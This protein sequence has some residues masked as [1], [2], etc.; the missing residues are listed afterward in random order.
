MNNVLFTP[1][2][3]GRI[4]LG[5]RVVMAPLTRLRADRDGDMPNALMREHYRQRASDGGLII[6]EATTISPTA[7]GYLGAPGLYTDAQVAGWRAIVDAVHQRGGRILAQLWHVGR[8]SHASLAGGAA[9]VTASAVPYEGL[10]FTTAGWTPVSPAR[11]LETGEIA[12]IVADYAAAAQRARDAGFDGIEIHAA[13]GYL[14]DQ[15][16][17]D[18]SNRRDDR[19]GGS[20]ENRTRLLME[21]VQATR[22]VWGGGRIGVRISPSSSFNGMSDSDPD[23]VF[24]H[25]AESLADQDLAYLHVVEPRVVGSEAV[26]DG[27]QP[28]ASRELRPRFGGPVIAAGGFAGAEAQTEISHGNVDAV[29]FGRHFIANPDLPVRLRAGL[30]LNPYNRA[31][32]YGGGAQGYTDYPAAALAA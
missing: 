6:T 26:A 15:F 27:L 3:L 9:P 7:R 29:A 13:N 28:V 18:G 4:R 20:I 1:L 32:F 30:A 25:I 8:T 19:Y 11:A 16:I 12:G 17:Q 23:A 22:A 5:H 10:A 14:L 21:V 31:T 24:G 2:D